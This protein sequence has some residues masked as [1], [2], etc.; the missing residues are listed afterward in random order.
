MTSQALCSCPWC[1]PFQ[2]CEFAPDL[3]YP[4]LPS[5]VFR[6]GLTAMITPAFPVQCIGEVDRLDL[7]LQSSNFG[8]AHGLCSTPYASFGCLWTT[9]EN[10]CQS[11]D[12]LTWR[13]LRS[14]PYRYLLKVRRS[15]SLSVT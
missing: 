7:F 8:F 14:P 2:G 9:R 5:L 11:R 13:F 15:H 4:I 12:A 1:K 3:L 10:A 6:V